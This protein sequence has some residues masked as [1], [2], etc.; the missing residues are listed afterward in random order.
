LEL[1]LLYF[2]NH[3]NIVKFYGRFNDEYHNLLLME[4]IKGGELLSKLES[5]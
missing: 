1:K 4:Y 3:P 5:D 2:L